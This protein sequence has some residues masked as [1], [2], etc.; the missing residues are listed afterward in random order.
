MFVYNMLPRG[1]EDTTVDKAR[2]GWNEH[3]GNH[4]SLMLPD[5]AEPRF[6]INPRVVDARKLRL[7]KHREEQ[8]RFSVEGLQALHMALD[9]G[10]PA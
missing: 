1:I 3:I 7:R 2:L 9:A 4:N 8:G 10:R 5:E 6:L